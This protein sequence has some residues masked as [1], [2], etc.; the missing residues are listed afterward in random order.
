M[1]TVWE[2]PKDL[3]HKGRASVLLKEIGKENI[4]AL[5]YFAKGSNVALTK[6]IISMMETISDLKEVHRLEE[7]VEHPNKEIR[8]E[9]IRV[10]GMAG[11]VEANKILIKFLL[12]VDVEVRVYAAKK[13][14]YLGDKDTFEFIMS[15]A[16][17]KDFRKRTKQ[18]KSAL[19]KYL[20]NAQTEEVYDL[21]RSFLK[22]WSLFSAGRHN[23]TRFAV[24]SALEAKATPKAKEVLEEGTG[25]FGRSVRDACKSALSKMT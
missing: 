4:A 19:L 12:D 1:G 15:L 24:V 23:E 18:E 22:T 7:F 11:N 6:E 3:D 9:I 13:L 8:L 14:K 10:L 20:A 17:D 2:N 25:V 21:F 16:Q 5:L